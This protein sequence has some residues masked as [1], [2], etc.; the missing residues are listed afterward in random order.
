DLQSKLLTVIQNKEVSRL[1]S[2][3]KIGLDFRLITATNKP[4]LD[5][6][7][8]GNFRE[9]LLYRVN[10]VQIELPPLRSRR[11]DI[12]L[13]AN[14]FLIEYKKKYQRTNLMI[15]D[16]AID[17]LQNYSWPGNVRELRHTVEKT[18]I[19]TDSDKL[20]PDDFFFPKTSKTVNLESNFNL[21]ENEKDIIIRAL[22]QYKSNMS[23]VARELGITRAT[24]YRKLKKYDI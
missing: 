13:L 24:L 18:V 20:S 14:G 9:D 16:E 12:P 11:E 21:D 3:K 23:Q 22:N 4:L 1:G 7:H 19:M 6:V 5:M 8:E 15:S 2:A 10:T 17:K